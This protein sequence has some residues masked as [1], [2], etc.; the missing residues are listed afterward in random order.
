MLFRSQK[1][2]K[3]NDVAD[4]FL[5]TSYFAPITIG[6]I[7]DLVATLRA[8]LFEFKLDFT[9]YE[10]PV[11]L[12]KIKIRFYSD[13]SSSPDAS[14]P[15]TN[16]LTI[17]TTP[18]IDTFTVAPQHNLVQVI[19]SDTANLAPSVSQSD[20]IWVQIVLPFNTALA[21]SFGTDITDTYITK[22]KFTYYK[23]A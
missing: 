11:D 2:Q 18:L 14:N 1:T 23:L 16:W 22:G 3:G 17:S 19:M 15:L 9:N 21:S 10:V 8:R 6:Q 7:S 5:S 4:L 13:S 12:T 20:K